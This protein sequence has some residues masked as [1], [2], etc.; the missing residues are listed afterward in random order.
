VLSVEL[1]DDELGI[2]VK[3]AVDAGTCLAITGPSGA[4]K[5]TILRAIA[6][7]RPG[8]E[9]V[10]DGEDWTARPPE[11]RPVGFVFQD[12]A[13]FPHLTARQNVAYGST[14]AKADALL[15]RFGLEH[16]AHAKPR[17][18]SGGERQRV[19]LARALAREPRVLLLDEPLAALDV[20]TKAGATR[21]LAN[22][23]AH[24][25]VPSILVT[26]DFTEAATFAD[27]VAVL[28]GG[29]IVQEGTAAEL[30]AR[31]ASAFVADLTGAVV[32]TGIAHPQPDGLTRVELDGGGTLLSVDPGDGPVAAT[33]HPWEITLG[34]ESQGSARNRLEATVETISTVG[35][36]VRIG[37][38]AGQP[39]VAEVTAPA[40]EALRLHPGSRVTA[41]FKAAATR[42]VAR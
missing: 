26:H 13:L 24:A 38:D 25:A 41:S 8:A 1:D 42:L 33:V 36:R 19:A 14:P 11:K 21:A 17:T 15:Q 29:R 30:A 31:P 22:A 3:L 35:G 6:G 9:V 39:L 32:L 18:L 5:T 40:V 4:G 20:R 16:R 7:L 2:H 34:D 28:D 12:H 27:R 10:C 23:L 37:L